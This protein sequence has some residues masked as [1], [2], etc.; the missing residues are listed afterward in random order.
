MRR[1]FILPAAKAESIFVLK[2]S[3]CRCDPP[4]IRN[5]RYLLFLP[6]NKKH[7]FNDLCLISSL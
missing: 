5:G 6:I 7:S 3:S 1:R 4:E 2:N